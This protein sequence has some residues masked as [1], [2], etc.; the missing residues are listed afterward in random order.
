MGEK[1][2][3]KVTQ[4]EFLRVYLETGGVMKEMARRL[5][6]SYTAVRNRII[7]MRE[8]GKLNADHNI[9]NYRPG[10]GRR[11]T[12]VSKTLDKQGNPK[13]YSLVEKPQVPEEMFREP[14]GAPARVSTLRDRDGQ[15]IQQWEITKPDEI[16]PLEAIREAM[17]TFREKIPAI[18][19]IERPKIE[20][21][22][23]LTNLYV[24]SDA[25]IGGLAWKEE[26]GEDWDLK[27]AEKMLTG[28]FSAMIGQSPKA[29]KCIVALLGDWL[30]YDKLEAVTTLSNN[31]LDSDGRRGKMIKAAI[32]IARAVIREALK[33]HDTVEVLIAEGNHDIIGAA[34]LREL[35][36]V[37]YEMEPR[38]RVIED[39][40]PYY[41]IAAGD[42]FLGFHHGHLKGLGKKG[43]PKTG[44]ELV[45][46]F[47]DEFAELWGRTKKR[48]IHTGHLHYVMEA[49]PRGARVMQHPTLAARDGWAA[50]N[51]YGSLRE[52]RAITYHEKY[53]Q[54]GT[55]NVSPEMV[56]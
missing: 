24:L 48:Y 33:H 34:W 2:E 7:R 29:Q 50:R 49:E 30:H 6:I 14:L 12:K 10:E 11:I 16:D 8:K 25:H 53:G 47:A 9:P 42:V 3:P 51:G 31:V 38:V 40:R 22:K 21:E 45:A 35:F 36:A 17:E 13:S 18:L 19:P 46:L 15:I 44:E 43:Q 20:L 23:S 26:T 56:A 55:V 5:P 39:E 54:T 27:I 37:A 32:R 4:E 28:A 52:A 1:T 41:A